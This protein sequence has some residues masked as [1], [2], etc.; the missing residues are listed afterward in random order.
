MHDEHSPNATG[1]FFTRFLILIVTI[2]N[3]M[4]Y[5]YSLYRAIRRLLLDSTE[6]APTINTMTTTKYLS[7]SVLFYFRCTCAMLFAD[8]LTATGI[9]IS[10]KFRLMA[11]TVARINVE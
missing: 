10:S 5:I 6:I 3:L 4:I 7:V 8:P 11:S 2:E 1:A 9:V